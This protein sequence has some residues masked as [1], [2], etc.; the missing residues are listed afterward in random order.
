VSHSHPS[1][2]Q[3]FFLLGLGTSLPRIGPLFLFFFLFV[4]WSDL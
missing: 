3:A 1:I 2:A 4:L